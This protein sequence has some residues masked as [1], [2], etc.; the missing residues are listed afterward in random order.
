M[1]LKVEFVRYRNVLCATILEQGEEIKR[2][3]FAFEHNGYTLSSNTHPDLN[4]MWFYLH[5]KILEKDNWT[6]IYRYTTA[7]QAKESL[8]GFRAAIE[9][10][11][12]SLSQ[13]QSQTPDIETVVVG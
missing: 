3:D 7:E 8:R 2:G 13:N 1:S 4:N 12:D 6:I 9:A 10:Y 5:G 11:N